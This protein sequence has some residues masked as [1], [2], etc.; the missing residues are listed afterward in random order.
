MRS[1]IGV[2]RPSVIVISL[3]CRRL[4]PHRSLSLGLAHMS[5]K[6]CCDGLRNIILHL[7]N[8]VGLAIVVLRPTV[9]AGQGIEELR[10]DTDAII[11]PANAAF[12]DIMDAEFASDLPDIN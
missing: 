1:P 8:F 4:L 5:R 12:Q 6:D 2:H 7:K 10:T 3:P 11:T 9:C